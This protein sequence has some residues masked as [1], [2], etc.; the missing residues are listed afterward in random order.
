MF[1]QAATGEE[2]LIKRIPL[3][4]RF[5]IRTLVYLVLAVAIAL[6]AYKIGYHN[7]ASVRGGRILETAKVVSLKQLDAATN[8]QEFFYEG[9]DK[10]YHYFRVMNVGYYR[11]IRALVRVPADGFEGDGSGRLNKIWRVL[12]IE[13]GK[14][15]SPDDLPNGGI[16]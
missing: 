14:L 5:T 6:G 4:S 13:D 12:T 7:A 15:K 16:F 8:G 9:S 2:T 10:S 1:V 11:L 3:N